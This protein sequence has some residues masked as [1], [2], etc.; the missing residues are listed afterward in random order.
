LPVLTE[1]NQVLTNKVVE[2]KSTLSEVKPKQGKEGKAHTYNSTLMAML[3]R[4][5][6]DSGIPEERLCQVVHY[7]YAALFHKPYDGDVPSAQCVRDWIDDLNYKDMEMLTALLKN[8]VQDFA[9]FSE[10]RKAEI[11][12]FVQEF[13]ATLMRNSAER[14]WKPTVLWG[15]LAEPSVEKN[16]ADAILTH[17]FQQEPDAAFQP[18]KLSDPL[19]QEAWDLL[20]EKIKSKSA[21]MRDVWTN[22]WKLDLQSDDTKEYVQELIDLRAGLANLRDSRFASLRNKT[23]AKEE[24]PIKVPMPRWLRLFQ[25]MFFSIRHHSQTT[26]EVFKHVDDLRNCT[27]LGMDRAAARVLCR[28]NIIQSDLHVARSEHVPVAGRMSKEEK[29]TEAKRASLKRTSVTCKRITEMALA[30]A[31][32]NYTRHSMEAVRLARRPEAIAKRKRESDVFQ[33]DMTAKL[34]YWGN[35][36]RTEDEAKLAATAAATPLVKKKKDDGKHP[37]EGKINA[38]KAVFTERNLTHVTHT[39]AANGQKAKVLTGDDLMKAVYE[40][41]DGIE[42]EERTA[43]INECCDK[44]EEASS[45]R[46]AK[47]AKASCG[48]EA[49]TS[50]GAPGPS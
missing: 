4:L 42:E 23:Q 18:S 50:S 33:E 24:A 45:A 25:S 14:V 17:V 15:C 12:T 16:V 43:I 13:R 3:R 2:L 41:L 27:N 40:Y 1:C 20:K 36:Q 37:L 31:A 6:A 8:K 49:G 30:S 9:A 7:V 47:K 11:V 38:V 44:H 48:V 32:K 5:V 10:E 39:Q 19:E 34:K 22:D 26:E 46:A 28:V 29:K 35:K 21:E